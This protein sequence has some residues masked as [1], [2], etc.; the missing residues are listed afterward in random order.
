MKLNR[1]KITK[2]ILDFAFKFP[3]LF[4]KH[5]QYHAKSF[6]SGSDFIK[7]KKDA[8]ETKISLLDGQPYWKALSFSFLINRSDLEK[9]KKWKVKRSVFPYGDVSRYNIIPKQF[10]NNNS[11]SNLG[12]INV[13]DQTFMD[14]MNAVYIDSEYLKTVNISL[15]T[16][17]S[18]LSMIT[19]YVRLNSDASNMINDV[20]VPAMN[21]FF[22]LD[23]LN[24]FN[25]KR[26][27]MSHLIES[28]HAKEYLDENM[29]QVYLKAWEVVFY[30][31][32]EMK[33]K[34][35]K[36]ELYCISDF[37]IDREPPY[38]IDKDREEQIDGDHIVIGRNRKYITENISDKKDESFIVSRYDYIN[39]IDMAYIKTYPE[40]LLDKNYNFKNSYIMNCESHLSVTVFFL[41]D[42]KINILSSMIENIKPF[43]NK[44]NLAKLHQELFD[45]LYE[46]NSMKGW[47]VALDKS[48][49]Y[50]VL[51]EHRGYLKKSVK[52]MLD[53]VNGLHG[54]I[55]SI[56]SM[57]ENR[58]QISNIKYNKRY[59]VIVFILVVIQIMLAAMTIKWSDQNTWYSS[60]I[61][62][63]KNTL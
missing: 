58:I 56:Y 37:Y 1:R 27:G 28:Q 39:E 8:P 24:V 17:P 44:N 45:I 23:S 13:N 29:R 38:F 55:K 10:D 52:I 46:L 30:L 53:R 26:R 15:S 63:F 34:K 42:K 33:I 9:I 35:N 20:K 6:H 54:T 21:E 59:S 4:P 32:N 19:F 14:E 62:W 40:H 22:E 11:Y 2:K 12:V 18:G 61:D 60:I 31:L 51:S 16:F 43:D 25:K 47:L 48:V 50:N 41:I 7:R 49:L 36:N 5:I 57:S 3:W